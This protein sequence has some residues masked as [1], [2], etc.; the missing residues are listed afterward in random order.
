MG[1]TNPLE[2]LGM[3]TFQPKHPTFICH[4]PPEERP[5]AWAEIERERQEQRERQ[6]RADEERFWGR[7]T[8]LR[9]K[10]YANMRRKH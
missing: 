7:N 9:D 3:S 2:K 1:D 5:A 10:V 6:A 4:L 8:R